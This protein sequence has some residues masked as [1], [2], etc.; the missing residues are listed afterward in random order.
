MN[1][2]VNQTK[3]K[4]TVFDSF[5]TRPVL[6]RLCVVCV[7]R[8]VFSLEQVLPDNRPEIRKKP[9]VNPRCI[10]CQPSIF[11]VDLK[12]ESWGFEVRSSGWKFLKVHLKCSIDSV[13]LF[14]F[15]ARVSV[16]SQATSRFFP[17]PSISS[18]SGLDKDDKVFDLQTVKTWKL[19]K[20]RMARWKDEFQALLFLWSCVFLWLSVVCCVCCVCV[21]LVPCA[22]S[23]CCVLCVRWWHT[24]HNTLSASS[25]THKTTVITF[26]H[27]HSAQDKKLRPT[28]PHRLCVVWLFCCCCLGWYPKI[29]FF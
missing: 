24:I 29:F 14:N 28:K 27:P 4:K 5:S 2:L 18:S 25:A 1:N 12:F 20:G 17:N 10:L 13:Q 21:C 9:D 8:A 23:Q 11:Q 7:L 3:T 15:L 6:L 26:A 16:K 22:L 19:I